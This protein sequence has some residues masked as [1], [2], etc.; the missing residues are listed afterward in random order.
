MHAGGGWGYCPPT[1]FLLTPSKFDLEQ[2]EQE[3]RESRHK[4][5]NDTKYLRRSLFL[6][7]HNRTKKCYGAKAFRAFL[8]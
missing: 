6:L 5:E 8:V 3:R 4:N 7:Y 1:D 2:N